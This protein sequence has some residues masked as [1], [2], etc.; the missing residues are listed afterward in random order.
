M[1][2][3]IDDDP[4]PTSFPPERFRRAMAQLHAH[5]FR[6]LRLSEAAARLQAGR[7]L[8]QRTVVL[9]FDDGD[10]SVYERAWPVLQAY[11]MSATVFVMPAAPGMSDGEA[12]RTFHGR[13]LLTAG[14]IREL[15][16]AGIEL[17]AHT[18]SHPVLP[19]LTTPEIE[20]EVRTS[21]AALEDLLGARV[22]AFAYPY[23]RHDW[24]CRQ[25]VGQHFTCACSDALALATPTD[26]VLA[27]PRVEAHYLRNERLFDLIFTTRLAWYLRL[28]KIP[29]HIRRVVLAPSLRQ[30]RP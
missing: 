25:I 5:D 3:A 15:H 4:V 16:Q 21:R 14:Q 11:D 19:R 1:F 20:H 30:G 7:S 10:A 24:R 17:G 18:L 9:T 6:T 2:H 8:P 22:S 29:R 23:G 26:D 27:L 28:R 12:T 13:R